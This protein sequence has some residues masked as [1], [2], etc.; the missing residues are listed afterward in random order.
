VKRLYTVL[1]TLFVLSGFCQAQKI[2]A[3]DLRMLRQKEDTLKAL[4]KNL[5][6]DSLPAGRMR[7]DSLFVRTLVRT[8]QVKNSFFY[9]FDSVRGI[10]K[11]IIPGR[12]Q[13]YKY[14]HLMDLLN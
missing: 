8:L 7:N 9:G 10:S 13:L 5:I 14:A 11:I 3:A 4:A 6:V 1:F 2:A 12:G